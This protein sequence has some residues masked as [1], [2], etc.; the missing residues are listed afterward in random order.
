MVT[1]QAKSQI[2]ATYASIRAR[3]LALF[4]IACMS[5]GAAAQEFKPNVIV[6]INALPI[7][8]RDDIVTMQSDV[9]QYLN[10][11]RY[12]G[13][14]W[15]G[16]KIPIDVTVFIMSGNQQ[17]R[18]YAGRLFF[19]SRVNLSGGITSPI[20]K[21]LDQAWSFPYTLNQQLSYQTLRFDEYSTLLDFYNFIALG[22]DADCFEQLSGR[23]FYEQA[24]ELVL[25]G[26]NRSA[27]GYTTLVA[28]PGEFTRISLVTELLDPRFEEFRKLIFEY[29]ADGMDKLAKNKDAARAG[30]TAIIKKMAEYKRNKVTQ[31]SYFMQ[32]FFDAKQSELAEL[33]KGTNNTDM[34]DAMRVLDPANFSVFEQAVRK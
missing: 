30:V 1:A 3:A 9:L 32:L 4:F 31:R 5:A 14:D 22:L 11:Q 8:Q 26:A 21:V 10:N 13:K 7:N 29:H 27:S 12:T 34:L 18:R 15:E 28:E 25:L 16:E 2:L 20:L 6:D 23:A 19:N 24:R 33:F 17:Q